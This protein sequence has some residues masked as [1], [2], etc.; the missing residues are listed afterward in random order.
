MQVG[1]IAVFEDRGI[2]ADP[3]PAINR[4][5]YALY[6]LLKDAF[7]IYRL[8][9]LLFHA[10]HVNNPAEVFGWWDFLH[11]AVQQQSIGTTIDEVFLFN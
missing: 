5:T 8:V 9:V 7:T 6:C 1:N 10:I 11:H 2:G 3:V 4:H